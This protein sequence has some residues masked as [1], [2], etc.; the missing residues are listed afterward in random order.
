ME[1]SSDP[2]AAF[3]DAA[4]GYGT[5]RCSGGAALCR[6]VTPDSVVDA[7]DA[8]P[9]DPAYKGLAGPA[10]ADWLRKLDAKSGPWFAVTVN[11]GTRHPFSDGAAERSQSES[12]AGD[13]ED[14]RP[15]TTTV[16]PD[17]QA[18]FVLMA[19]H[20]RRGSGDLNGTGDSL[21]FR[22]QWREYRVHIAA[23]VTRPRSRFTN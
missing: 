6:D 18:A 12:G 4:F 21:L 19:R 1:P 9:A 5:T 20:F 23:S 2:A 14:P 10:A 3:N 7:A 11:A 13:A 16:Q 17:R 22:I 8:R 15:I